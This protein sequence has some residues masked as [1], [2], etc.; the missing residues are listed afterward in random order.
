[1]RRDLYVI[2]ARNPDGSL[3][4]KGRQP[5]SDF[6]MGAIHGMGEDAIAQVIF[7][8]LPKATLSGMAGVTAW[9]RMI[10]P[11]YVAR[12]KTW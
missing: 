9:V 8:K 2:E 5:E 3:D 7:R 1:M 11:R 10:D 12:V 6:G 4:L